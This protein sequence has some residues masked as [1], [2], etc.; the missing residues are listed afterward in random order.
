[1]PQS[2][3]S[4]PLPVYQLPWLTPEFIDLITDDEQ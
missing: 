4:P 2:A 3:L 1:L